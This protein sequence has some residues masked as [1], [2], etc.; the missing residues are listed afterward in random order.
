MGSASRFQ[1]ARSPGSRELEGPAEDCPSYLSPELLLRGC[2]GGSPWAIRTSASWAPPVRFAPRVEGGK[3]GLVLLG[4]G[5]KQS[6]HV[7]G[8]WG[9][10]MGSHFPQLP[11]L[12]ELGAASVSFT[13]ESSAK[14]SCCT[15]ASQS[16]SDPILLPTQVPPPPPRSRNVFQITLQT[17]PTRRVGW[18]LSLAFRTLDPHPAWVG[19]LQTPTHACLLQA[20]GLAPA[21][22]S[23][24]SSVLGRPAQ[25][26]SFQ[27]GW[28]PGYSIL[29][30]IGHR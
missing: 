17:F 3:M 6:E 4:F 24:S 22:H 23:C 2:L 9:G 27:R 26:T 15:S 11:P 16:H 12:G 10:A 18:G 7:G 13:L 29:C 8:A 25:G 28:G 14:S 21:P 1:G 19:Q 5:G 30:L 20:K